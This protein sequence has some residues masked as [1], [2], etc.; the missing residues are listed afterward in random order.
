VAD[1]APASILYL[2][3]YSNNICSN[4]WPVSVFLTSNLKGSSPSLKHLLLNILGN[5]HI[6]ML[7][8]KGK[9]LVV[10]KHW[11]VSILINMEFF[12]WQTSNSYHFDLYV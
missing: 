7:F 10:K 11:T 4:K 9:F 8:V 6:K 5:T 3:R 12:L 1:L 2:Q